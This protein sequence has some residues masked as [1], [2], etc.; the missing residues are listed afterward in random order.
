[1]RIRPPHVVGSKDEPPATHVYHGL[2]ASSEGAGGEGPMESLLPD[3]EEPLA[4]APEAPVEMTEG[5]SLQD[6]TTPTLVRQDENGHQMTGETQPVAPSIPSAPPGPQVPQPGPKPLLKTTTPPRPRSA[7][8][9]P[10]APPESPSVE[11]LLSGL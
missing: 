4:P 8:T 9:A 5:P 1:M 7:P 2:T 3:S 10:S 11:Q 6:L